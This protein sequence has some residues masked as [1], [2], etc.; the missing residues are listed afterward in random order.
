MDFNSLGVGQPFYILQKSDK[1][2]L[3]M[4]V[5]KSKS[6]PRSPYQSQQPNIFNGLATM[7]GQNQVIDVVVSVGNSDI[8][9]SNLPISSE[10]TT[11]NN[12]NTFVSCSREATLQ[13]VDGMMQASKKALEQT[14]YH[15][16]VLTEGEKMLERLNPRYKEEK[17]RDRSLKSLEE[18]QSATDKKVDTIL[19]RLEELFTTSKKRES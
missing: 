16:L 10:S 1:P 14:E 13:A 4:G 6:E 9:F 12:G 15:N 2:I 18:R 5:I 19:S 11:Y 8:P 3:Q 7:Q 17:E